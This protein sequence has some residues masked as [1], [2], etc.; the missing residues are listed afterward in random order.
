MKAILFPGQGVQ[1]R[2]MGEGL[3]SLFKEYTDLASGVLGYSIEDLC[4]HDPEEKLGQTRYTQPALYVVNALNYY[5]GRR[6][7]DFQADYFMGHSLGEYNALLAAGAFD[8][9]TGLKLVRKRGE[10]MG[11]ASGGGMAAVLGLKSAQIEK[12]LVDGGFHD[13]DLANYN[14]PTQLVISG[15]VESI[16]RAV[17]ILEQENARSIQLNVSGAFHSRYMRDAQNEFREFIETFSFQRPEIPV[18][19]NSTA[20][21]YQGDDI[22]RTLC[23]QIASPVLWVDSVRYLMGRGVTDYVEVGSAIFMKMVNETLRTGQPLVLED[24]SLVRPDTTDG[25]AANSESLYRAEQTGA[26]GYFGRIREPE[27]HDP[28][29]NFDPIEK[30]AGKIEARMLGSEDFRRDYGLRLSYAAGSMHAGIA[31][32]DLVTKMGQAGLMSYFGADGLSLEQIEEAIRHI[33]G[34]LT[35]NEPYGMNLPYRP[36]NPVLEMDTVALYLKHGIRF[37]EV[38]GYLQLT[39]PVVLYRLRGLRRDQDGRIACEHRV[40]AKVSRLETAEAFMSPAPERIVARLLETGAITPEQAQLGRQVP[41]SHDICVQADSGGYSE[42]GIASVLMPA[43]IALK[44]RMMKQ[45]GYGKSIRLG[46]SGGIG[47]PEA[48]ASAFVMGA[49]FILTG[50]IN[51][52][53]IESG[54]S[55]S[56]KDMLQDIGVHDTDYAPAGDGFG[57]GARVQVLKRGVFFPARARKLHQLYDRYPS[58][59]A[60]PREIIAQ[61][62][63]KYFRRSIDEVWRETVSGLA[64]KGG[65]DAIERAHKDPRHKMMLIFGWYFDYSFK[66]ALEG[67]Q[68]H[69]LDYQ[70]HTGP[71]LG[72]FN[73]W[74]KGTGLEN[75]RRRRADEIAAKLMAET[76]AVLNGGFSRFFA[77]PAL[78]ARGAVRE[79]AAL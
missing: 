64:G 60:L 62:E 71:A 61:L 31:S 32:K 16:A 46:L 30:I 27:R 41:L 39:D 25:A 54:A 29:T 66:A 24:D 52:C 21:P 38:S 13:I 50:S 3:F 78:H 19:A 58:L 8:F 5:H 9:V 20:R 34:R 65:Q 77:K 7:G 74:V 14:T 1:R 45:H 22:A 56:A 67:R 6:K 23:E 57:T 70:I 47:A 69:R 48:A 68:E 51:Q 79:A 42:G 26:T 35:R 59:E 55:E 72:A 36:D 76:A 53:T 11:A 18:I 33:Q 4:L 10:L 17:K 49:D 75:W 37:V 43:M 63:N 28:E 2:G 44:D 73:Q 15:P 12:V 40:L